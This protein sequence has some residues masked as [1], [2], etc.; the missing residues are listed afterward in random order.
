MDVLLVERIQ[1]Q[2]AHFL[3]E[4]EVDSAFHSHSVVASPTHNLFFCSFKVRHRGISALF[5]WAVVSCMEKKHKRA[6]A[7]SS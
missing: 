4:M 3:E 7:L 5:E 1:I 6:A 2:S